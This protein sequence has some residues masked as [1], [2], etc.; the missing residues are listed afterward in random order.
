M[1]AEV[2]AAKLDSLAR[3]LQR[4]ESKKPFTPETL[5]RDADL[6]DV[7]SVNLERAVQACVDAASLCL[8][9]ESAPAPATMADAFASLGTLGWIDRPTADR[10]IKAVGFRNIA[11][12]E[13]EKIDWKIVHRIAH[14]HLDDFRSFARQLATRAGL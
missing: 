1:R 12:H 7:I 13:Y 9:D 4:I 10:M 2:L 5:A 6:Q 11:V 3:C 8:A 14:A